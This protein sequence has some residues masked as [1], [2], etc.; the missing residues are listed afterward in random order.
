MVRGARA[1]QRITIG[2]EIRFFFMGLK[3]SIGCGGRK[4]V[5]GARAIKRM[6][7]GIERGLF[8]MEWKA[9]TLSQ[10]EDIVKAAIRRHRCKSRR[11][12]SRRQARMAG[13]RADAAGVSI[14]LLR[15]SWSQLR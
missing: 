1:I 8:V 3:A 11:L 14:F 12:F 9:A 15:R 13:V 10:V 4:M 7:I 2:I 6:T 5:R